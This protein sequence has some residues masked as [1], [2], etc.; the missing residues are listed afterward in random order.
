MCPDSIWIYPLITISVSGI[1]H[2]TPAT[3][4]PS[5]HS[6]APW[7]KTTTGSWRSL[8]SGSWLENWQA[9]REASASNWLSLSLSCT[10]PIES[11]YSGRP[12]V[13]WRAFE[14]FHQCHMC[15]FLVN[16]LL[17]EGNIELKALLFGTFIH[18]LSLLS[19]IH[20]IWCLAEQCWVIVLI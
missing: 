14:I 2:R 4:E 13:N 3:P 11:V 18:P 15:T 17:N 19:F 10:T 6:W 12:A 1:T 20:I 8:S 5:T 7:M 16:H 9:S